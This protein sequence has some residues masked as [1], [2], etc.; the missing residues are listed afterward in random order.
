MRNFDGAAL[1]VFSMRRTLLMTVVVGLGGALPATVSADNS[2]ADPSTSPPPLRAVLESCRHSGL[3]EERVTEFTGSMPALTGAPRMR[4]R[5]DLERRRPGRRHWRRV[6][7]AT[8]FSR[9]ERSLPSR[10]GFIVHKRVIGLPVPAAY[11]ARVSFA[12]ERLD[13]TVLRRA[14]RFTPR[15]RQPDLQPV[16]LLAL[17]PGLPG[18]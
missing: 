2:S 14:Q 1:S 11:R 8:G 10:A 7:V 6:T 18:L 15:C 13:H 3:D 17:P 12:W 16:S 4:M 5:F 9:W